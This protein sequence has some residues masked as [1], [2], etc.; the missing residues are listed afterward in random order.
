MTADNI[1][2]LVIAVLVV[3]YLVF[4]LVFPEKL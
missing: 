1:A 2:A 3:G 4:A